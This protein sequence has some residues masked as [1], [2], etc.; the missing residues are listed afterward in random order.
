MWESPGG[1]HDLNVHSIG[2]ERL[3][4]SEDC[5][6]NRHVRIFSTSFEVFKKTNYIFYQ[7]I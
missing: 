1:G 6:V 3:H 4:L 5:H 2:P 7:N